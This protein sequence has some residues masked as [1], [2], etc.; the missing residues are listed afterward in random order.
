MRGNSRTSCVGA[1]LMKR[2][3]LVLFLTVIFCS[4]V[5]PQGRYENEEYI[6]R[7]TRENWLVF[8]DYS[9]NIIDDLELKDQS[10]EDI[11][12]TLPTPSPFTAT[13]DTDIELK[14]NILLVG[15][16][17][18][19][20]D[21]EEEGKYS[22][23]GSVGSITH[24]IGLFSAGNIG[25]RGYITKWGLE[26]DLV[27]F[28]KFMDKGLSFDASF[29]GYMSDGDGRSG[30]VKQDFSMYEAG[31]DIRGYFNT[32]ISLLDTSDGTAYIGG[33]LLYSLAN[34]LTI[35]NSAPAWGGT[36]LYEFQY[37]IPQNMFF[38]I[39]GAKLYWE[40]DRTTVDVWASASLDRS[41]TIGIRLSQSF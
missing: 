30:V 26:G 27:K 28:G 35:E 7:P 23:Y 41:Y 32:K 40:K 13:N 10:V 8:I 16:S 24:S 38:L 22:L 5:F 21:K 17:Y 12:G 9:L 39:L 14:E 1:I 6:N 18:V 3:F 2:G 29:Y 34:E 37:D 25:L 31:L 33:Q 11:T 15:L 19:L 20:V 36:G 4:A